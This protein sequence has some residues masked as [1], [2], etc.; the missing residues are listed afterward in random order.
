MHGNLF[1]DIVNIS[2]DLCQSVSPISVDRGGD[3]YQEQAVMGDPVAGDS[4]VGW[5]GARMRSLRSL[6]AAI[7][8]NFFS[9]F[10]KPLGQ[11]FAESC[12]TCPDVM[13][14][15]PGPAYCCGDAG[16]GPRLVYRFGARV[17]QRPTE[18]GRLAAVTDLHWIRSS[19]ALPFYKLFQAPKKDSVF[20]WFLI[21]SK[22]EGAGLLIP[23]APLSNH[24]PLPRTT[25][26][27]VRHGKLIPSL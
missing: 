23:F 5:V 7:S 25:T 26:S 18:E 3:Q 8:V 11:S 2:P 24:H 21:I 19:S 1:H 9:E 4:C 10:H 16:R 22:K 17:H 13:A 6:I 15:T 14:T 12:A 27:T 20:W